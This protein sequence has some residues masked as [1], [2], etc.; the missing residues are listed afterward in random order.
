MKETN[1]IINF[2]L[3]NI[4][5]NAYLFVEAGKI[6]LDA[7]T[8]VYKVDVELYYFDRALSNLET[9]FSSSKKV[10][11][12][13]EEYPDTP[14]ICM[15][16]NLSHFSLFYTSKNFIKQKQILRSPMTNLNNIIIFENNFKCDEC[17]IKNN[18]KV[19][20]KMQNISCCYECIKVK[21]DKIVEGR[22]VALIGDNYMS[23]E[24]NKKLLL[25]KNIKSSNFII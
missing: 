24:C 21:T 23:R 15:F 3:T 20:F 5:N 16:Y 22:A 7:V 13:R 9:K 10:F 11:K 4:K 14:K 18:K 1:S 2:D 19:F 6:H 12:F 25:F 17:F 8:K